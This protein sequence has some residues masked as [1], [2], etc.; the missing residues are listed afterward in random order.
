M[1]AATGDS[2]YEAS[3]MGED[4]LKRTKLPD[5]ED[6]LVVDRLFQ[7]FQGSNRGKPIPG[8]I[9]RL[10]FSNFPCGSRSDRQ[11][12]HFF[13]YVGQETIFRQPSSNVVKLKIMGYLSK[14]KTA[15]ESFPSALQVSFDCLYGPKTN[16]KLVMAGMAFVQWMAR[17][18]SEAALA[19]IAPV[20]VSGLL[21]YTRE[22]EEA[23]GLG[24]ALYH[25]RCLLLY[26]RH[27]L[28]L[29]VLNLVHNYRE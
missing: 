9:S 19:P 20:L 1:V 5:L 15:A 14:S 25:A 18:S 22:N 13:L 10:W 24:T 6:K 23:R 21:K 3:S 4:G 12:G 29:W 8:T 17:M 2:Y 27:I 11:P 16:T 26:R 28:T 7:M